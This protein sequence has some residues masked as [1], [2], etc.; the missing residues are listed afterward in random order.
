MSLGTGLFYYV[1]RSG[2]FLERFRENMSVQ[3]HMVLILEIFSRNLGMALE[4]KTERLFRNVGK[5]CQ[6]SLRNIPG[7]RSFF[8]CNINILWSL[9]LLILAVWKCVCMCVY[10]CVCMCVY[11]CVCVCVYVCVCI[12]V[13]M[14]VCMCVCV[15]VCMCLCV[16]YPELRILK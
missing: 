4:D 11:M 3:P 6:Y 7:R 8:G 10:M 9:L 1:E 14:C 2:K 13:C 5:I 12:C 16:K 15:C